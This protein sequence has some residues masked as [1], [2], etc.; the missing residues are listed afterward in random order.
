M[1]R[2]KKYIVALGIIMV[3]FLMWTALDD[4]TT[5]NEPALLGEWI[6]VIGGAPVMIFLLY[7]FIRDV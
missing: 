2:Y 3:F 4:I 5:G 6:V 7:I 1:M